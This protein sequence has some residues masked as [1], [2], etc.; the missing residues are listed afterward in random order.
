MSD[1]NPSQDWWD[2]DEEPVLPD[3]CPNC[4]IE[5]DDIDY[6]YQICHFCGYNNNTWED[7]EEDDLP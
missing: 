1:I 4:H 7:D 2:D 6:E 5:Y 3:T